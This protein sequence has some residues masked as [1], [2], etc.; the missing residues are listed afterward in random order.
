[1]KTPF[2]YVFAAIL[3]AVIF[4]QSG[5]AAPPA[6]IPVAIESR[7]SVVLSFGRAGNLVELFPDVGSEVRTGALIARLDT[8]DLTLQIERNNVQINYLSNLAKTT[9]GLVKQGVKTPDDLNRTRTEQ[10]VLEAENRILRQQVDASRLVAPFSGAVVERHARQHQWVDAGMPIVELVNNI[11]LRA[12][13]DVPTEAAS[14]LKKGSQATLVLPDVGAN[15]TVEVEA[16]ARKVE[17]R[18]NTVRV[19]WALPKGASAAVHG[20]KGVVRP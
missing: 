5:F 19:I 8:R 9:A 18:S 2:L 11:G 1:M 14:Q 3:A 20:M 6:E 17:L 13:G 10:R 16:I 7:Q 4:S 15:Y 12:I